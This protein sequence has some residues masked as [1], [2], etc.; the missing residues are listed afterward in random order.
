MLSKTLEL[1]TPCNTAYNV[2]VVSTYPYVL[3]LVKVDEI[4]KFVQKAAHSPSTTAHRR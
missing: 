3:T 1:F 4:V 2:I